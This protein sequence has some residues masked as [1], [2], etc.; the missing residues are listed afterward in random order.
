MDVRDERDMDARLYQSERGCASF[1]ID[2]RANDIAARLLESEY[3]RDGRLDVPGIGIGHGLH[4]YGRAAAERNA[5]HH[6]P[7]CNFTQT[8]SPPRF[9]RRR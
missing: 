3:L 9:W 6:H 4:A 5:A 1:V 7:T 8:V 2:G